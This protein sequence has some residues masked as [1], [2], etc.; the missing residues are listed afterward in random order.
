MEFTSS[1]LQ[2]L[3]ELA[4]LCRDR[5]INMTAQLIERAAVISR[6]ELDAA[7]PAVPDKKVEED[8]VK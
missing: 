2:H 3:N 7:K 8:H 6:I 4:A 1:L 5:E